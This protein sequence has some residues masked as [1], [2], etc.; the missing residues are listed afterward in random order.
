MTPK[1]NGTSVAKKI[2]T[3]CQSIVSPQA[4]HAA[5]PTSTGGTTVTVIF[6]TRSTRLPA[7]GMPD[8]C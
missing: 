2:R 5:R 7:A 4:S 8:L 3:A 6:A 1:P